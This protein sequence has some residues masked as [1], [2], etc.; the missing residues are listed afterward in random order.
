MPGF[1][2]EVRLWSEIKH[3]ILRKYLRLFLNKLGASGRIYYVDGFAGQGKYDDGKEG[4]AL[5]AARLA[6]EDAAKGKNTL[7]CINVEADA[8]TFANLKLRYFFI[9]KQWPNKEFK[10]IFRRQ[11]GRDSR[12]TQNQTTLFFIDPLGAKGVELPLLN[13]IRTRSKGKS[14][15]LLRFDDWRISRTIGNIAGLTSTFDPIRLK[16]ALSLLRL[17]QGLVDPQ[18]IKKALEDGRIER[19]ELVKSFCRLVT[20]EGAV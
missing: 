13:E 9:R 5:I 18:I 10:W 11:A 12:I 2:A 6:E 14:E 1:H 20:E 15:I 17:L 8:Q 4:S 16:A 7:R 19:V 3:D